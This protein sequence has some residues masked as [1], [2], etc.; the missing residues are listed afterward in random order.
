MARANTFWVGLCGIAVAA[1]DGCGPSVVKPDLGLLSGSRPYRY[2]DQD[3]AHVLQSYVRAGL[4]DYEGLVAHREPLE[5]YYALLGVTGPSITPDQFRSRVAATA[6]WINAYNA[7]VLEAVLEQYPVKTMY[8]LALPRLETEYRFIVDGKV[9]TL[10]EVEAAMLASSGGDIRVLFATSRAAMGSPL[11]SEDP[12]RPE[13]LDRQL[14]AAAARALDDP[15]ILQIDPSTHCILLWQMIFR[16][17]QE[18]EDYWR[19]RRRAH[20]ARLLDVLAELASTKRRA[21]LQAAVG[22]TFR[23]MPFDRTLNGISRRPRVP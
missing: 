1:V 8:D 22:Y 7:L 4:V 17:Q 10:S 16:R 21:A 12:M 20:S 14:T 2:T 19:S 3:W 6:Y 13:S 15:N 23:E 11:L 9:R 5:R 18:F